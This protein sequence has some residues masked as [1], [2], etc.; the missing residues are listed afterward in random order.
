MSIIWIFF[1]ANFL[2]DILQTTGDILGIPAMILGMTFLA[3]GN[4]A[5]GNVYT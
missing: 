1:S 2:I 4:S 5:P 3:L